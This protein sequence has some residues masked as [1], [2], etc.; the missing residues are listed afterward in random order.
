MVDVRTFF[1]RV[2]AGGGSPAPALTISVVDLFFYVMDL[3]FLGE[4]LTNRGGCGIVE[5]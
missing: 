2:Y 4:L 3:G 1:I 5:V